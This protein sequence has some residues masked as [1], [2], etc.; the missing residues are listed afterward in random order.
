MAALVAGCGYAP[1]AEVLPGGARTLALKPVANHTGTGELDVR[2]QAALRHRFL[3]HAEARLTSE[4]RADLVLSV[5]LTEF[6]IARALDVGES[7]FRSFGFYLAGNMT[8][9]DR[10]TGRIWLADSPVSASVSRTHPAEL[11]E[12]PA[13]RDGGIDAVVSAFADSIQRTIFRVF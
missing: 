6:T 13:I 1:N 3:G 4:E 7:E 9:R 8:L 10:R 12:T 2:L 11:L 5:N